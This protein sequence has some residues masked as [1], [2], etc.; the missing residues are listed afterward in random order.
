[1]VC[2]TLQGKYNPVYDVGHILILVAIPV[3]VSPGSYLPTDRRF[4][5]CAAWHL[6]GKK[7]KIHISQVKSFLTR[8]K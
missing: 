3:V 2:E 6:P 7:D 5:G 1:M 8:H 4:D